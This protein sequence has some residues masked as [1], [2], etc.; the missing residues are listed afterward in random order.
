MKNQVKKDTLLK[1]VKDLD[2]LIRQLQKLSI[3]I[4][5]GR[6]VPAYRECNRLIAYLIKERDELIENSEEDITNDK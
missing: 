2:V 4:E 3:T 6:E 5:A 1:N